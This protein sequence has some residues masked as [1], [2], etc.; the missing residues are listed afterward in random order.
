MSPLLYKF[1][2]D[3]LIPSI[4][5]VFRRA[6]ISDTD[7]FLFC[8]TNNL[9]I[10]GSYESSITTVA[11][12]SLNLALNLALQRYYSVVDHSTKFVKYILVVLNLVSLGP[13]Y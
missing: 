4:S 13:T 2:H 11:P 12:A 3:S 7:N 6:L 1:S 8:S 5:L 10:F 9:M